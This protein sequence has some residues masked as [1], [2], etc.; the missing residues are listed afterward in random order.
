MS[1]PPPSEKDLLGRR[2]VRFWEQTD[3]DRAFRGSFGAYMTQVEGEA[4]D[5]VFDG[6][7]FPL[8]LDL[9]C[10]HGRFLRWLAPRADR[11]A[12]LDRSRRLLGVAGEELEKDPLPV[13]AGLL[14]GSAEDIPLKDGSVDGI[15]CVRVVQ[16]LPHQDKALAEMRRV[17][18]PGGALILVQYNWASPHGLFRAFKIPVKWALRRLIRALGREPAFDEP[19]GWTCWPSLKREL[20]AAGL[21]V[22]Q[23]TGSWLFPL[24]YCRSKRTNQAWGPFLRLA[25]AYEKL[26]DTPP[27]R[28]FGGYLIVRCTPRDRRS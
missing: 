25:L 5:R 6:R 24:Q 17:L 28:Y 11:L 4:L 21:A 7:R 13:P 19:T 1:Q 2:K 8:L 12:G 14:W 27:F 26:A 16:H 3:Y 15:T 22:E 23:A 10:G 20:A 18:K 9:G